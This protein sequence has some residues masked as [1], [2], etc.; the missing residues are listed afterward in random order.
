MILS[1]TEM[2]GATCAPNCF[3]QQVCGQFSS[4]SIRL[5]VPMAAY[6]HCIRPNSKTTHAATYLARPWRAGADS[7]LLGE[8]AKL[9][10]GLA[11][12]ITTGEGESGAASSLAL[13]LGLPLVQQ[14]AAFAGQCVVPLLFPV[15][16]SSGCITCTLRCPG[17]AQSFPHLLKFF[18]TD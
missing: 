7:E 13:Q 12:I 10:Q 15:T 5:K 11:L 4:C 9:V 6:A 17:M 3:L 14:A 2:A 8:Q 1:S 16:L 18:Q